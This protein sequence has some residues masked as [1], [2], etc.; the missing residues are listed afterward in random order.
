MLQESIAKDIFF[1][2]PLDEPDIQAGRSLIYRPWGTRT[3][4][5]LYTTSSDLT[6]LWIRPL[7]MLPEE[8]TLGIYK[9]YADDNRSFHI[10][11]GGGHENGSPVKK[12]DILSA[13][14]TCV[15]VKANDT[16]FLYFNLI[17][18]GPEV[19]ATANVTMRAFEYLEKNGDTIEREQSR[20]S[21]NLQLPE[22]IPPIEEIMHL[23]PGDEDNTWVV[24][25]GRYLPVYDSRWW[26]DPEVTYEA[27]ERPP[28]MLRIN[29]GELR[30]DW[31]E[32]GNTIAVI[33]DFTKPSVLLLGESVAFDLFAFDQWSIVL[34]VWFI[35]VDKFIGGGNF[36]GRHE[37]PDME[38]FD[39]IIR[40]KDGRVM[41][42]GTDLHWRE[43][44]ARVLP[45]EILRATLG[46]P[47]ETAIELAKAKW[48]KTWSDIWAGAQDRREDSVDI[49]P[50]NNP[51]EPFIR[52]L[53]ERDATVTIKARGTQA[54]IPSLH[55]VEQR[56]PSAM[57]S[58][59][60]RLGYMFPK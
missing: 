27:N 53:A 25:P 28:L 5:L 19:P 15:P 36:I 45:N 10:I 55:N 33:E 6:S 18:T 48:S 32:S 4:K 49:G 47:R 7:K 16:G 3:I 17:H 14:E 8:I 52:R 24:S 21:L 50:V 56:R 12:K 29:Q 41:L 30:I 26:P 22:D 39:L 35:W 23:I 57:T 51:V 11:W 1:P 31:G 46:M 60:V 44:W 59:D 9:A 38:R 54:H 20:L 42:A 58:S 37:V 13:F 2:F 40:R 34:R 43:V